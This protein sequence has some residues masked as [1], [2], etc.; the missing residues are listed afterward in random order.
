MSFLEEYLKHSQDFIPEDSECVIQAKGFKDD[1]KGLQRVHTDCANKREVWRLCCEHM[2]DG[3][4]REGQSR[5]AEDMKQ[6]VSMS[7]SAEYCTANT[8]WWFTSTNTLRS[9]KYASSCE[10]K[11]EKL[12]PRLTRSTLQQ[13]GNITTKLFLK[14]ELFITLHVA[15]LWRTHTKFGRPLLTVVASGKLRCQDMPAT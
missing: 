4:I 6:P 3:W 13:T 11:P 9:A 1:T 14:K 5:K 8:I 10:M 15:M 12:E 2:R 7:N